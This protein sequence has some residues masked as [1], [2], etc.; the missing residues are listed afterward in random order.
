MNQVS[1]REQVFRYSSLL[2]LM[3]GTVV[4]IPLEDKPLGFSLLALGVGC[5]A[6]TSVRFAQHIILVFISIGL[7]AATPISP[8]IDDAHFLTMGGYL[9]L[10]VLIPLFV[11]RYIYKESVIRFPIG[12]HTWTKGHI[13]Y[14]L[15]AAVLSYVLLPLWMST[16]GGY[17]YW[18][19]VLEPLQLFVL[20]LGTNGL[21]IWDE[22]F[23]IITVLALLRKHLPFYQ[24]NLVQAV[25]FT[26]FLY[27]LGFRGWAPFAIF[28][29]ALLQGIVFKKTENLL[30][31]IAIHLTIDLVLYLALINAFYPDVLNIFITN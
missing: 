26:S 6:A 4:A 24:A 28:P 27:E 14:L 17:Q 13:G 22:L 30:Y 31:I 5:L 1:T 9:S 18:T 15:L 10:A 25:L 11:T 20:F 19:V 7:L 29:F 16:T 3:A 2:L 23:F 21:G 8:D 12:K